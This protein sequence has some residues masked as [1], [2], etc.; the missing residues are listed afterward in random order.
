MQIF[1]EGL[2]AITSAQSDQSQ[3]Q[4]IVSLWVFGWQMSVDRFH[5]GWRFHWNIQTQ[6][7]QVSAVFLDQS[8][9]YVML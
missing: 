6:G 2:P 1:G 7:F 5:V 4:Y 8:K 9:F 3:K